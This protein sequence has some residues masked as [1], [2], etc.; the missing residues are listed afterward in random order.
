MKTSQQ[1]YFEELKNLQDGTI[2]NLTKVPSDEPR[3]VIDSNTRK[4]TVPNEFKFL[5]VKN[6]ANAEKIYFEIDRCFDSEDLSNH[7]IAVQ[8]SDA[9]TLCDDNTIVGI[10]AV[11]DID[12][13]TEPGKILFRWTIKHEVTFKATDIAFAIRFYTVGDDNK[14]T[15]SFNTVS[16]CL[17]V[18]DTLDTTNDA[19]QRYANILDEWLEK[20]GNIESSIDSKISGMKT[21]IEILK[22]EAHTHQNKAVIDK[23]SES[24]YGKLLFDG[25]VI[26]DG[27]SREYVDTE[28]AKKVSNSDFDI[29]K[30]DIQDNKSS[31]SELKEDLGDI[32]SKDSDRLNLYD[33]VSYRQGYYDGSK[34]TTFGKSLI[35]ASGLVKYNDR[36]TFSDD[37]LIGSTYYTVCIDSENNI[38]ARPR[39]NTNTIAFT[40]EALKGK[41][42]SVYV[43]VPEDYDISKFIAVI[44]SQIPDTWTL[45]EKVNFSLKD[46]SV[47]HNTIADNTIETKKY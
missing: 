11:T 35:I 19:I 8:Y 21:D 38:L 6:D 12:L 10:D 24:D 44:G 39:N 15:Y 34:W 28:L 2:K 7:T 22:Y 27:A 26:C 30:N 13:T 23:L 25:N 17:P 1:E 33:G 3:F 40:N 41:G 29:A 46:G 32:A 18:L 36:L 14:F 20:M 42:F 43:R 5:A 4:I 31:I 45:G 37:A 47:T 16:V 9:S